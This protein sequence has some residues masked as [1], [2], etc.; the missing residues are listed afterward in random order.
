[1]T[2][3]QEIDLEI[4]MISFL[5]EH[6]VK[7]SLTDIRRGI[8][9]EFIRTSSEGALS[10]RPHP[11]ALGA[12]L[13]HPYITTD[14]A[15]AQMELVTPAMNDK[16]A[17]FETLESLH[18]FVAAQLPADEVMWG[19]SM[20]PVLPGEGAIAIADYGRS[21]AGQ[22]KMRYR[23][24][25]ANRY[26]KH[27]QLISGIHY[28]FSLPES[29]WKVLHS[30]T[31][32]PLA[33]EDFVSERYFHLIRNVVRHGWVI[34]YLFGASP[35]VD[36][37]YVSANEGALEKF[38]DNTG[39][40]PWATSLRLSNLGYSSSEQSLF[41]MSFNSKHAF[42]SGLCRVLM[43]PSERYS[44]LGDDKQLNTSVLQVEN[45]LYGWVRPKIVAE[46]QRPLAAMCNH[47]VQYIELRSLDNNPYLPMGISEQQ[48]HFLD[49]FL[50]FCALAP[51][52][53]ITDEERKLIAHRQELVTSLGR[54]PDLM[55]PT[56]RGEVSLVALGGALLQ[57][58]KPVANLFDD[59]FDTQTYASGLAQEEAKFTNSALTPSAKVL[60][61][62]RKV[63]AGHTE[64]VQQLSSLHMKQHLE[65]QV[66]PNEI[67]RL[68]QLAAD[69]L[70]AQAE[71]EEQQE[72]S[73]EEFVQD[74][75]RVDCDSEYQG[76]EHQ[77]VAN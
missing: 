24:G 63:R 52:M 67:T 5:N 62:M 34:P 70:L 39:Y 41:P 69:S 55:L 28:N 6:G 31:Q 76:C 12:A 13:T 27:M 40:L 23:Q 57:A 44:E 35:A 37:S 54:K 73:F 49:L 74:K 25:L 10:E 7:A 20:P 22:L 60:A 65:K 26:G 17:M 3:N 64:L 50:T 33:L 43:Q 1:M 14:F 75:S 36:S 29:F 8:E 66:S 15:E 47:G 11:K 18:H 72:S 77:T 21:N 45:E 53:D 71:M 16:R 56:L 61:D 46:G 19:A 48:S 9:R 32:S 68:T 2:E 30:H 51:S 42:L 58:M 38:D 4:D 59:V